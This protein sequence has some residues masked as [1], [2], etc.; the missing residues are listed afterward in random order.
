MKK[1]LFSMIVPLFC[2]ICCLGIIL[3]GFPEILRITHWSRYFIFIFVILCLYPY[4]YQRKNAKL[5]GGFWIAFILIGIIYM[6]TIIE[7]MHVGYNLITDAYA[8]YSNYVFNQYT[9][10]NNIF[11]RYDQ[12]TFFFLYVSIFF[13][14]AI[15]TFWQTKHYLAI[16]MITFIPF[17]FVL[18]YQTPISWFFALPLFMFWFFMLLSNKG[19]KGNVNATKKTACVLSITCL[20]IVFVL[21]PL[22]TYEL[23]GASGTIRE[24]IIY[25]LDDILYNLTHAD[26][27]DGEVDLGK[28]GNR[29]YA[30]ITHIN[31]SVENIKGDL[32]L[33]EYSG[34]IYKDNRWESLS[35]ETYETM[36]D[37]D[38][39]QVD[40]WI[41]NKNSELHQLL[42][43]MDNIGYIEIEDH[44]PSKRYALL[45]YFMMYSSSELMNWYDGYRTGQKD[46]MTYRAYNFD[47]RAFYFSD[48]IE[49]KYVDFVKQNYL[50]VPDTMKQLFDEI[51]PEYLFLS[52]DVN[53]VTTFI[54]NYLKENAE[55]TLTP[56]RTPDNKDFVEYFLKE[57][58]RGYCVHFATTATLMLR[59]FGIPARYVTGYYLPSYE[60]SF[61]LGNIQ[62]ND[63]HAWVEIFDSKRG[64][65][66]VEFTPGYVMGNGVKSTS[67]VVKNTKRP[68]SN[69][70]Q[71]NNTTENKTTQNQN[72]VSKQKSKE[73]TFKASTNLIIVVA[74]VGITILLIGQRRIRMK[75]RKKKCLTSDY[76]KGILYSYILLRKIMKED[77]ME[78]SVQSICREAMYSDHEMNKEQCEKVYAYMLKMYKE[79]SR[80]LPIY[81]KL[82][83]RYIHAV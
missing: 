39:S 64:W 62:D 3:N 15:Y 68:D 24:R 7:G 66:P 31:V 27:K 32:Y 55:Y 2:I 73:A 36:K 81:K 53:E 35:E 72:N 60:I 21:T 54:Q 80:K 78:A 43:L 23:R 34:A 9:L 14:V 82:W 58:K 4:L 16:F 50:Q 13:F 20:L 45:P 69:S 56:G 22:H 37:Y 59:Y 8:S 65:T 57:N 77:E 71:S 48:M 49:D 46:E 38:W 75:I 19:R 70:P 6:S 29:M 11:L 61:G 51:F 18:L 74:T 5:I 42:L 47:D 63:A 33:K 12:Y 30:N 25:R 79:F 44:R 26:E 52:T 41:Y 10:A 28:A 17:F 76:K 67:P 83:L 1:Y 40:S